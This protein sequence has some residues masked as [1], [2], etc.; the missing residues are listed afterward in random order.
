[1]IFHKKFLHFECFLRRV[2][3]GVAYNSLSNKSKQNKHLMAMIVAQLIPRLFPIPEGQG[4]NTVI[5]NFYKTFYCY[6][7]VKKDEK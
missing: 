3:W 2:R 6:L 4:S 1:M 7:F 5:V